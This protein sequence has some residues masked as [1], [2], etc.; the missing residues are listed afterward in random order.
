[1]MFKAE[2]MEFCDLD[3][4]A[5]DGQYTIDHFYAKLFKLPQTMKTE[6]GRKEAQRRA[7]LMQNYLDDLRQEMA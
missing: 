7:K 6:A 2:Q 5:Q 1:M 4:S 3:E